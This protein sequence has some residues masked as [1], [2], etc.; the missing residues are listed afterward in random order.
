MMGILKS[1]MLIL[2][3]FPVIFAAGQHFNENSFVR[4]TTADGLSHNTV[5][6]I[7]QDS[8]GY[9]WITTAS[10]LNRFDGSRFIRFHSTSDSASIAAEELGGIAKLNKCHLGIYT[11]GLHIVDTRTGETHNIFIP[12]HDK[13]Y[14]F[15]FNMIARA[16][17]DE[18]GD[19]FILARSG[20]YHYD[21]NFRLLSRFDYY[22][23]SEVPVTHFYFGRDLFEMDSRRLLIVSIGG[24]YIYDKEKRSIKK[25][26][27]ADCP[28]MAA[29]LDYPNSYTPYTF[30]QQKRGHL[31]MLKANGDSIIY[32]NT[33]K[34]S[35]VATRLPFTPAEN[36]F[37]WRSRLIPVNDTVF[38]IT[39]HS[40]GFYKIRF[41][42]ESGIAKFYPEKYC[43]SYLCY[44][45]LTDK[46]NS[47]WVATNR[48]LLRQDAGRKHV[49]VE[50][51]PVYIKDSIPNI[52]VDDIYV[53]G[54]K[55]YAGGRDAGG[56]LLFDKKTLRFDKQLIFRKYNNRSNSIYA[57]TAVDSSSLLL[58]TNGAILLFNSKKNTVTNISPPEWTEGA[59]TSD[60]YKDRKANIWIGANMTFRYN[61]ESKKFVHVPTYERILSV[62]RVI[63]EDTSGHVWM[64]G[65]S[66]AR[67]NINLQ[68]FD[69][70]VDSF[71]YIKMPDKQVNSFAIDQQN[72]IW[73]NS[74]NNGLI[75]Y[76]ITRQSY[77][78]FTRSHGLPDDNIASMIIIGKNLW[79]ACYSGIA[80]INLQT[81]KIVSFGK[82]DGFPD[83]TVVRGARFFYDTALHQ[84][85]M[86]FSDAIAR[87]N[88]DDML[89]PK[90][91][92]NVFIE[93]L[94]ISGKKIN[95]LPQQ[96]ISTSWQDN[97][98]RITIG[99]INF[100]V[101]NSQ[102]FAY[103]IL[104]DSTTAWQQLGS[105]PSFSISNLLPGTHIIQVKCFS[106]N[107]HWLPQL[108]EFRI[109]VLPPFWKK[110]WFEL[111]LIL[112][113]ILFIY[114]F[115]RWKTGQARKK[116]MEKT[117][118]QKLKAD[119][120]KSQ[121]ELEQISNYFSSSLAD[122]KTE[123]E[124]LWDVAQ[125]LIGR[126]NYVDC[127][128]YL[129]NED[130]TKMVQKA[131]Y[132][133]KGKPEY[134]NAHVFDVLPGQ[135]IV[136]HVMESRQPILLSDS[137]TDSR[138]RMDE[139][140]RL[141][142]ICVPVIH[143]DELLGI[144][145]SEHHLPGYFTERD[146]KILTTIATLIG[147]KIKQIASDQSL[148]A[149]RQELAGINEQLA[150]A[151]LSALQ[152]Q[153]NPHFVFNALNS[154]KRMILDEENEKASR[155]LSKFA[156]M[157]RMT[158]NH[159]K[160]TFVT[161]AENIQYLKAYLEMEQLRFDASF[162][163]K[164]SVDESIDTEETAIPALMMQPLVE[165]AIW[166]GLM[167]IEADKKILI[168]FTQ[169]QQQI[170]CT[171]ED[172][173]IGIRQAEKLKA[174]GRPSHQ[175]TGIGNLNKRIRILNEKYDSNCTLTIMDL[176]ESGKGSRGT[177]A[178]LSF[179][180]INF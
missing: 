107:N 141:S 90:S 57:I 18:K 74:N 128:I 33:I 61:P 123:E 82:E 103:R 117:H 25:M 58:G 5:T 64:A 34:N 177:R 13:Q 52:K 146:I 155:Y 23:E 132:G 44:D 99:A 60:L 10:G 167:H 56:L 59:W 144:I 159:S 161:L 87:F 95:F 170:T 158:L 39:G 68:R 130:K 112:L 3:L 89:K 69:M 131:A 84:L 126:M 150:E 29:F 71:P 136:G 153:M 37:H 106:L 83:M 76:D 26:D 154:I 102:R 125:N 88:P 22:K 118:I 135:G 24:L 138:Y 124:V 140:F 2:L 175:S 51:L 67:Y 166:H 119:D 165:N 7:V 46:Q 30:F 148:E 73:L 77:R 86:G 101:G 157:I 176:M 93:S 6:G 20:F 35:K 160:E 78:H 168:G 172:N 143:N 49:R 9:V 180:L 81:F 19:I 45:L 21:K 171:I 63:Q 15:K 114:L 27:A 70:M 31:F 121:F 50:P 47:L 179:N 14:Q 72:R 32:I 92:P 85:Y 62:P 134:I 55:V 147:N 164:I 79:L 91:P 142:E 53:L 129:W 98:I 36:E 178:V 100:S 48:G 163:W 162:S 12:Y 116:E 40:S 4:Y 80:C 108:K 17:G 151:K 43:P 145:D 110:G 152:A 41:Y 16:M 115:I 28:A 109:T 173:G 156:L 105:H 111:M 94:Q 113:A 122:K 65:H 169:D 42:P 38:Y 8:T 66:I 127:M 133:P 1:A 96:H 75:C 149:K 54:D 11:T 137:R 120:Y 174:A 97:E 104:K 139:A